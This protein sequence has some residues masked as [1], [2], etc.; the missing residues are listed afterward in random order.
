MSLPFTAD[1]VRLKNNNP[2]NAPDYTEHDFISLRRYNGE[3]L[4][5]TQAD[6]NLELLRRALLGLDAN[7]RHLDQKVI[8]I[9]E[10]FINNLFN[11][12]IFQNQLTNYINN[13]VNEIIN[14][15][16]NSPIFNDYINQFNDQYFNQN[17]QSYFNTYLDEADINVTQEIDLTEVQNLI[18]ARVTEIVQVVDIE[19]IIRTLQNYVNQQIE[20]LNQAINVRLQTMETV[21]QSILD[22]LDQLIDGG[23]VDFSE[24]I[25]LIQQ[26]GENVETNAD[27]IALLAQS[28]QQNT[29]AINGLVDNINDMID[30][31]NALGQA[32]QD[33]SQAMKDGFD[34][35]NDWIKGIFKDITDAI[36]DL[37]D[38]IAANAD[39]IADLWDFV[40]QMAQDLWNAIGQIWGQLDTVFEA[41][42]DLEAIICELDLKINA[43]KAFV[44][45]I[46]IEFITI[47]EGGS[48]SDL[49][50]LSAQQLPDTG[51]AQADLQGCGGPTFEKMIEEQKKKKAPARFAREEKRRQRDEARKKAQGM[52]Q[53]QRDA[54]G[55]VENLRKAVNN[56]QNKGF[57]APTISTFIHTFLTK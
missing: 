44:D 55:P 16:I 39:Q 30:S 36:A 22:I 18:D 38:Q 47:C 33:L 57:N 42:K 25:A 37:G 24:V 29:E 48:T 3:P 52:K 1:I 19:E 32:L 27:N 12:Q 49:P 53:F 34:A 2:G 8:T 31:I 21:L 6:D 43:L 26:L 15:I 54:K 40:G 7:I 28:V 9:D 20:L 45:A 17:F 5:H 11:N 35:L 56:A 4:N 51:P 23:E 14:Q 50:V 10:D 46:G 13:S 41:L